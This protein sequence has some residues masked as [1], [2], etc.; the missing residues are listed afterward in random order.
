ML[1]GCNN[2]WAFMQISNFYFIVFYHYPLATLATPGRLEGYGLL[3]RERPS[4]ATADR[5]PH[6]LTN[7]VNVEWNLAL[8]PNSRVQRASY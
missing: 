6:R 5:E 8:Y 2:L 7:K 1:P 4:R 3:L